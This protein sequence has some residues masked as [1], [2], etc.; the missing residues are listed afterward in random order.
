[1]AGVAK[2]RLA[3]ERKAWR[4]DK[5]FG[6]HARPETADDG[7]VNL[8]RWKCHIPGKTETDWAGGFYPLTMEFSEDYPTK[9]PKVCA[10]VG[11]A[12]AAAAAAAAMLARAFCGHPCSI[13]PTP[14]CVL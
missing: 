3:E 2:G 9:P 8:M 1:M 14:L 12:A 6:F 5:P 10:R 4:K 7:S 13:T 11:R